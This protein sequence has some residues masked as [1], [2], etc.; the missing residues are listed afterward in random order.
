MKR[1]VTALALTFTLLAPVA[2]VGTPSGDNTDGTSTRSVSVSLPTQGGD[3]FLCKYI[4]SL[5]HCK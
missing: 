1:T 4:P 2:S 5:P 3:G